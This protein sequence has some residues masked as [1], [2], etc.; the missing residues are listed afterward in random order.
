MNEVQFR[1]EAVDSD[2]LATATVIQ[3]TGP[4]EELLHL[5]QVGANVVGGEVERI[6]DVDGTVYYEN[7]HPEWN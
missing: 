5:L 4:K 2:S 3:I 6:S 7:P 1:I